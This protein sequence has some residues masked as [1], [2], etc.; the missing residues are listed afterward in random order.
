MKFHNLVSVSSG[1][2]EVRVKYFVWE[3]IYE[4]VYLYT[5]LVYNEYYSSICIVNSFVIVFSLHT[6]EFYN[7]LVTVLRVIAFILYLHSVVRQQ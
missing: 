3:R 1:V 7:L 6:V 2:T 4:C 5:P